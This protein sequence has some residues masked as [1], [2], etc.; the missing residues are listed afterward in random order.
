[1]VF[2]DKFQAL[3]CVVPLTSTSVV[4]VVIETLSSWL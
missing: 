1:M 3:C 4:S 2:A